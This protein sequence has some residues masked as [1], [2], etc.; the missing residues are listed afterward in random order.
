MAEYKNVSQ[1]LDSISFNRFHALVLFLCGF[2]LIFDGY[3]SQIIA[4]I[5]PQ[6]I[7]EWELTPVVAGSI[8]SY[9]FAGLMAGAAGFGML[10]DKIGRKGGLML[11]LSWF[12]CFSGAAAF[13]T[14]FKIFC[15]LRF[16]AGIGMGGAMPIVIALTS[17]FSPAR[18]R[19]K[20]VTA[21]FAGFTIGWALA[22]AVAMIV[23][24][25]WGWR[26]ALFMGFLPILFLPVLL[27]WCPESVRFLAGKNRMDA[28]VNIMR[29]VEVSAGESPVAWKK[30]HFAFGAG[31]AGSTKGKFMDIFRGGLATMTLL[32][33]F[34]YFFNLL[35]T[36]G[37][38]TWLPT[39]L[40]K[41]GFSI[42]K[43][44]SYGFVQAIGA[45]VGGFACGAL[46]DKFGRKTGLFICYFLG[47]FAV[48][49]FGSVTNTA[50]LYIIG[51]CAGMLIIG[52]MTGMQV[53]SGE[54]Y[55]THIRTTGAGWVMTIGRIGAILAGVLG[56]VLVGWGV[57]FKQ[58]FIFYSVPCFIL[59]GITLLFKVNKSEALESI[60]ERLKTARVR[61][62]NQV[63]LDTAS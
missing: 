17:E 15:I 48:W 52:A 36:Y 42:V 41:Q 18:I 58:F 6:V 61:D 28:A 16:L 34:T 10:A 13:A 35:V 26:T 43:S 29:R 19:A 54:T 33:W 47:G 38:S 11:A 9:G 2:V 22:G 50:S 37:L 60:T 31:G 32:L 1:W 20:C 14:N 44:Y 46:M 12:C 21:M 57:T 4:Y 5:M 55:P 30:E 7:K 53:V 45:S 63:V 62:K 56:G 25:V 39:L 49:A 27:K 8:A 51:G 24:P 3:D 59:A 23:I 40:V